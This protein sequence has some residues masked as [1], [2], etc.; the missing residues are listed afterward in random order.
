MHPRAATILLPRRPLP[1]S[2]E[3]T[4]LIEPPAPPPP[5]CTAGRTVYVGAAILGLLSLAAVGIL[6]PW[7]AP[8][9]ALAA[10][11]REVAPA[12]TPI[13]QPELTSASAPPSSGVRARLERRRPR[14]RPISFE[15][16]PLPGRLSADTLP[17]TSVYVDGRAVGRTPLLRVLA[18]GTHEVRFHDEALGIDQHMTVEVKP[19]QTVTLLQ[20]FKLRRE[21]ASR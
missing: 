13:P 9:P 1:R 11:R 21:A 20:L 4:K 3:V 7:L 18:P 10:V 5:N 2:L 14:P 19:K 17:P 15:Q 6:E 8:S 16:L 12:S